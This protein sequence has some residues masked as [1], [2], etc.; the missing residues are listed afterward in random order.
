MVEGTREGLSDVVLEASVNAA[1]LVGRSSQPNTEL[2]NVYEIQHRLDK[3][4]Q[5][6]TELMAVIPSNDS[7]RLSISSSGTSSHEH[8]IQ[9]FHLVVCRPGFGPQCRGGVTFTGEPR[10]NSRAR[11]RRVEARGVQIS[12]H[13]T[14]REVGVLKGP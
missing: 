4:K 3:I 9:T 2:D 5:L 1:T 11:E 7:N 6:M 14:L 10:L 13:M 8:R 12:A